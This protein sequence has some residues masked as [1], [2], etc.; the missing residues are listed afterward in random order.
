MEYNQQTYDKMRELAF[1]ILSDIKCGL[2]DNATLTEA[3][4]L[5]ASIKLQVKE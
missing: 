4:D 3:K 5:L 2:V 1:A